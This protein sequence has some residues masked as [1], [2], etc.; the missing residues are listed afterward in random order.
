MGCGQ[1]VTVAR[2]SLV[3]KGSLFLCGIK[4]GAGIAVAVPRLPHGRSR[5]GSVGLFCGSLGWDPALEQNCFT[6]ARSAPGLE[7]PP[8]PGDGRCQHPLHTGDHATNTP[9]AGRDNPRGWGYAPLC[10]L[11]P[12][13]T[14][15]SGSLR[16]PISPSHL[17]RSGAGCCQQRAAS[18]P[19]NGSFLARLRQ[20]R[21]LCGREGPG[22]RALASSPLGP[23]QP[24]AR[25]R[26]APAPH[27]HGGEDGLA[28]E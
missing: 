9:G 24:P 23:C 8:C 17:K 22:G 26:C 14:G 25:P 5:D 1:G 11:Q 15:S 21:A 16:V 3:G 12:L 13:R 4:E 2:H 6:S 18:S 10:C 27:P 19:L 28:R 7:S 20:Q